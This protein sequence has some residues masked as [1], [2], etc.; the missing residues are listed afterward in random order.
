MIGRSVYSIVC[1]L[2]AIFSHLLFCL[3]KNR[4]YFTSE[5]VRFEKLL[6][7]YLCN[8]T[9]FDHD[10]EGKLPS[11]YHGSGA[12]STVSLERKRYTQVD[13]KIDHKLS[14][15]AYTKKRQYDSFGILCIDIGATRTKFMYLKGGN[16]VI[17]PPLDSKSLWQSNGKRLLRDEGSL[18]ERLISHLREK[19]PKHVSL[20]ELDHVVFSVPGT[21]D[22]SR[23]DS[24]IVKNMPQFHSTFRGFNFKQTFRP[25]FK[26]A[27]IHAVA[28]NLAA[29]L[30]AA[31]KFDECKSALVLILG[32]AP[33]V[34]T[35]FRSAPSSKSIEC[36]IWQSWAWFTKIP[37]LDPYGYCGG[38]KMTEDG[39]FQLKDK[40]AYKIP[41]PKSRIR[42]AIDSNTWKRLRGNL[43]DF[44]TELQGNL[45]EEEATNVWVNRVQSSID[46]L[47]LRFHQVYGKPEKVIILGGNGIRCK[48]RIQTAEY[49][50]PDFARSGIIQVPVFIPD[51]DEEQQ[52]I[53]MGGL[54][55][56]AAYKRAHVYAPGPDPLARGWTRGGEIYLWVKRNDVIV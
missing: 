42:F 5:L 31:H 32:T 49:I 30:G 13:Y 25:V 45:S 14:N 37:L 29:A 19:L 56:V 54:A 41:H 35:F 1:D 6:T 48:N 40:Q 2:F 46:A 15:V 47:V 10:E 16:K 18:K 22:F 21:V 52:K 27:K 50:D 20:D 44:P 33:A 11:D 55:Q 39:D 9:Y 34:A 23:P 3:F 43:E 36:A 17:L 28:D 24:A 51:D 7:Q 8:E 4:S 38:L 26:N 53:H 12:E